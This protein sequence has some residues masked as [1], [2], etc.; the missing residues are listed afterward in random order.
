[1]VA[2]E[3]RLPQTPTAACHQPHFAGNLFDFGNVISFIRNQLRIHSVNGSQRRF[4][5]FS[6]IIPTLENAHRQVDQLPERGN[7][8]RSRQTNTKL[9]L[10]CRQRFEAQLSG[11]SM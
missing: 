7:I 11:G 1:M 5:L 9:W 4:Q 10:G 3:K 8:L 2:A 6:G